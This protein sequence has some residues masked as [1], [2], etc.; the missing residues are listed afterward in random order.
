MQLFKP[1]P[2]KN[3]SR[4]QK[5]VRKHWQGNNLEKEQKGV[6]NNLGFTFSR[7]ASAAGL[8]PSFIYNIFNNCFKSKGSNPRAE[9]LTNLV[10]ENSVSGTRLVP[11]LTK[12][13]TL[14][15]VPTVSLNI[16]EQEGGATDQDA[17]S[18]GKT[19]SSA[20]SSNWDCFLIS[21]WPMTS[22]SSWKPL[23]KSRGNPSSDES[24][25]RKARTYE[26]EQDPHWDL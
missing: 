4:G 12:N 5:R 7:C 14:G 10:P 23:Q 15:L 11:V 6:I 21:K 17:M 9:I 1:K 2:V 3:I 19:P 8:R 13:Q 18:S 16:T 22:K 26:D 20:Q 24:V 25:E